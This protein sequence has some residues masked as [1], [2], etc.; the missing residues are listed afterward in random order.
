FQ[1]RFASDN[2]CL[3]YLAAEKWKNGYACPKCG[4]THYCA[5]GTQYSRQCTRCKHTDSPTAG[6]LF[7]KVKFPLLKAF[8]IVYFVATSKKGISSTELSRKLGLRQKTCWYF[9]R[10]V[11]KAMESSGKYPLEGNV[12]VDEFFV[13]GQ[14]EGK[15][16]RGKEDKQLVV[17][18]IEKKG[19]GVSRM[20]GKVIEHADA[21]SL[22]GFMREKIAKKAKVRADSW[23]G[24]SPLKK[25][26]ENLQQ[27][28]SGKKGGNFPEIHRTIMMFKAW[29]RGIHHSVADLQAY[30]DEY[31][32]RFNRS[33]M[34]AAI[35]DNLILRMIKAKPYYLYA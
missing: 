1:Q 13:G 11:M 24:Y 33:F 6:T 25:D 27:I 23:Q 3:A 12:E 21:D 14:E 16:G 2:Q 26:F 30:I 8:Y 5:G 22:G 9:K 10:K 15:K 35:F 17:V 4:H 20:Y 31:T 18:A 19:R 32:Y 7:H 28:P 29:L 34:N